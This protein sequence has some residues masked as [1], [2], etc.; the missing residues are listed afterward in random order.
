[1][2]NY[3]KVFGLHPKKQ[4]F[5]DMDKVI[6]TIDQM[7][8]GSIRCIHSRGFEELV[9][10]HHCDEELE[11]LK[12]SEKL[13]ER[14]ITELFFIRQDSG[15]ICWGLIE[16]VSIGDHSEELGELVDSFI[17]DACLAPSMAGY[18]R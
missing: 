8:D 18:E 3:I 7:K 15:Q 14:L 2:I 10:G 11:R 17:S 6:F 1:M 5:V 16:S 13:L 9:K 4:T 12:Q